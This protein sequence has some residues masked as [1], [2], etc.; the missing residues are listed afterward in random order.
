MP[1]SKK[2][3]FP[4]LTASIPVAALDDFAFM[5]EAPETLRRLAIQSLQAFGAGLGLKLEARV[6]DILLSNPPELFEEFLLLERLKKAG[7]AA[8][9][10]KFNRYP[11][12]PRRFSYTVKLTGGKKDAFGTGYSF[13]S[14]K[15]ALRAALGEAVER[16]CLKVF[17]PKDFVDAPYEKVKDRAIDI[18]SLAGLS[19]EFRKKGHPRYELAYDEASVF[20]WVSGYSLSRGKEALLPLQLVT[21]AYSDAYRQ[22]TEPLIL[23]VYQQRRGGPRDA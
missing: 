15:H 9:W 4:E 1:D 20:R 19:P 16:Y 21:F 2:E 22:K 14:K 11:D 18:F 23:L 12:E 6:P 13:F 5:P 17:L 7:L 8:D 10:W 3:K